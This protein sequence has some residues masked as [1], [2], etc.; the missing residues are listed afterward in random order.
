MAK[1]LSKAEIR[2]NPLA[3]WITAALQWLRTHQALAGILLG[4]IILGAAGSGA[5]SWYQ[6]RREH[7]AQGILIKAQAVLV[8]EKEGAQ[9]K[10]EEA[11]TL[12]A[13]IAEKYSGTV[14]AEEALIRL[15]NIQFDGDKT[16]EA[17]ATFGKY[18]ST[19]P[20]GRFLIM[21]G[22]GKAYAEEKK[23]DLAAAESTLKGVID[24]AQGDPL[25]G[26]AYSTLAHVYEVM[27]KPEEALRI[28][29][30]VAEKFAQT[31]WA[32]NALQRM[33]VL[34]SK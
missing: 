18:L 7:E 13:E 28:Y 27:K 8:G 17:L 4:V 34:K 20:T 3:E 31:R 16:D 15:G 29:N 5:Y 6:A 33:S 23:G 9:A 12:Y 24:R 26:E 14:A 2:R 21:A 30:Q 25:A 32:Q 19:Y 1:E 22:V 11:K 10:P